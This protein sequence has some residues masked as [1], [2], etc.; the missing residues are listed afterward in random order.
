MKFSS[1]SHGNFGAC[2]PTTRL[3]TPEHREVDVVHFYWRLA[4]RQ[5]FELNPE[6][7]GECSKLSCTHLGRQA[8][9]Y[10]LQQRKVVG[11]KFWNIQI[12]PLCQRTSS[13]NGYGFW[14]KYIMV[15]NFF[16]CIHFLTFHLGFKTS[17]AVLATIY[18][19]IA[20]HE[21]PIYKMC[22][23]IFITEYRTW[24]QSA[25]SSSTHFPVPLKTAKGCGMFLKH[26]RT[27]YQV[28]WVF[29]VTEY[30]VIKAFYADT[31]T[32]NGDHSVW[33]AVQNCCF[34]SK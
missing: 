11:R 29:T 12:H 4:A 20:I 13:L 31:V 34:L 33:A 21:T 26:R 3:C 17:S 6:K 28:W 19:T 2:L 24:R 16:I 14:N 23:C 10:L 27:C 22:C 5:H 1:L 15:P 30:Y 9:K 8:L 7:A 32:R 25:F 18:G